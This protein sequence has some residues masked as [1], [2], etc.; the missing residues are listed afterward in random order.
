MN[1]AINASPLIFLNKIG[2]LG[3]L[4]ECFDNI[5]LTDEVLGEIN[6]TRYKGNKLEVC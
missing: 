3:L 2:R 5:Y 4:N 6:D 1:V